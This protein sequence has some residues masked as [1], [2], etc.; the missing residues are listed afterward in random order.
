MPI[1]ANVR[2]PVPGVCLSM[3]KIIAPLA[4]TNV[5]ANTVFDRRFAIERCERCC[6]LRLVLVVEKDAAERIEVVGVAL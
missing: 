2:S 1:T 6:G 3:A 5:P 4:N